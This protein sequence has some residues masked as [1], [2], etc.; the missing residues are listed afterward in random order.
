MV[1]HV[2]WWIGVSLNTTSLEDSR[3]FQAAALQTWLVLSSWVWMIPN[4][5]KQRS[6]GVS[7][8]GLS[9]GENCLTLR[10]LLSNGV[11][12]TAENTVY[13]LGYSELC[14]W[15][16]RSEVSSSPS[17]LSLSWLLKWNILN[18]LF[19]LLSCAEGW[20]LGFCVEVTSFVRKEGTKW[21][22]MIVFSIPGAGWF[23][24]S[25]PLLSGS[26]LLRILL[27]PHSTVYA[28]FTKVWVSNCVTVLFQV[29]GL[30]LFQVC[31][32]LNFQ[33][34]KGKGKF[35]GEQNGM[36]VNTDVLVAWDWSL[37][38]S[39]LWTET[40][41]V[42]TKCPLCLGQILICRTFYI[43]CAGKYKVVILCPPRVG[44]EILTLV[45]ICSENHISRCHKR[46]ICLMSSMIGP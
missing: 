17:T 14:V 44:D 33:G 28:E 29:G 12:H 6:R 32:V 15:L 5:S 37:P 27:I 20:D 7:S 35:L 10:S 18:S 2:F 26:V 4:N 8:G 46:G 19:L 40:N 41:L 42:H 38:Y 1:S 34:E 45:F 16:F 22:T 31:F 39:K 30:L 21:W 9:E 23:L 36:S 13:K 24:N 3:V 11:R 43:T 25:D